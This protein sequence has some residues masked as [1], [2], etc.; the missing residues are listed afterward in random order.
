MAS[1][2][3]FFTVACTSPGARDVTYP[4]HTG[5]VTDNADVLSPEFEDMLNLKLKDVD[6]SAQ[7]AVVTVQTTEP[8]VIEEYTMELAERW[9]V[10]DAEKDNGIIFLVAIEDRKTRIE[11]G[12]GLEGVINDAKAGRIL[13]DYVLIYF[14]DDNWEEGLNSGV[15]AIIK[16]VQSE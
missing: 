3:L 8:M 12:T 11:V 14:K 16:E 5:Y 2:V 9:G 6:E 7:I 13:D 10:G 15:D 1:I 4:E